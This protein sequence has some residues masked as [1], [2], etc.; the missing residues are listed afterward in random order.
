ME[1]NQYIILKL[2]LYIKF[3]EELKSFERFVYS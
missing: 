1:I 2:D 3:S